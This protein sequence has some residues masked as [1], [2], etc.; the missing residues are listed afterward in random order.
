[1]VHLADRDH[2]EIQVGEQV[3]LFNKKMITPL[4]LRKN[5]G[6][7]VVNPC[8]PATTRLGHAQYVQGRLGISPQPA[9]HHVGGEE[10][11]GAGGDRAPPAHRQR[12][13]QM[14]T[15]VNAVHPI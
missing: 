11:P 13:T 14:A 9:R 1:M 10:D 12:Q 15:R 7:P 3:V 5:P 8:L 4:D 6:I 2:F